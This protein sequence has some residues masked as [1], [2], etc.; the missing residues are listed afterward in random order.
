MIVLFLGIIRCAGDD[1]FVKPTAVAGTWT[2]THVVYDGILREEWNGVHLIFNENISDHRVYSMSETPYD[3]IWASEGTWSISANPHELILDDT[4]TVSYQVY[5]D[6]LIIK[7]QLPWT[8]QSTCAG[9]IC[10]PKVSGDWEFKF[11]R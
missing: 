4:L 7:C 6:Q 2:V 10:I 5:D 8:A 11:Q 9:G 3:S 1:D